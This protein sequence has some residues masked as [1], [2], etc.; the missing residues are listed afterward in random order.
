MEEKIFSSITKTI[1]NKGIFKHLWKMEEQ[2]K[3]K[4]EYSKSNF[5]YSKSIN[6]RV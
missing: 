4:Y 3:R 6:T 2:C 1:I 5:I